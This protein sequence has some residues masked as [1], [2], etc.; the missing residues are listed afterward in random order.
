M[1][2]FQAILWSLTHAVS[3]ANVESVRWSG[4]LDRVYLQNC[5]HL[6]VLTTEVS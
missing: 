2:L 6:L 4:K 3:G 1:F 5:H